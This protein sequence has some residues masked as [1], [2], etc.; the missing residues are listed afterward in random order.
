MKRHKNTLLNSP[1]KYI[2][3]RVIY[4]CRKLLIVVVFHEEMR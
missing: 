3:F 2:L 4:P 1:A